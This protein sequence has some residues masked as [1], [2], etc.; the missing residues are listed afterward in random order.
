MVC[1]ESGN[2]LLDVT[3]SHT[4][5]NT[6]ALSSQKKKPFITKKTAN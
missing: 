6:Q 4:Y 5:N 3:E 1:A 2:I